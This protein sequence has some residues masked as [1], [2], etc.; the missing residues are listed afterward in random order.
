MSSASLSDL[1][2]SLL[3]RHC[4]SKSSLLR[5]P[6]HI[7]CCEG[8]SIWQ[9]SV[10]A[11]SLTRCRCLL[12]FKKAR[13]NPDPFRR[14]P[15]AGKGGGK[16]EVERRAYREAERA[17]LLAKRVEQTMMKVQNITH[18]DHSQPHAEAFEAA[19]SA[20]WSSVIRMSH[21]R[22]CSYASVAM[23]VDCVSIVS[24]NTKKLS[25]VCHVYNMFH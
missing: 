24:H 19:V 20:A 21:S 11:A 15:S 13:I 12:Q 16:D 1:C 6:L 5:L 8:S 17:H 22:A 9:R 4:T 14:P 7:Q 18:S 10:S 2:L 23:Q 3:S 25:R